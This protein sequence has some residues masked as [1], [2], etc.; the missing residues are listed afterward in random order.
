MIALIDAD[1]VLRRVGF[2]TE[3]ESPEIAIYRTDEMMEG[4]LAETKATEYE[5]WLSDHRE[6][7]FR[8]HIYPAYKANR[9]AAYPKHDNVIME[10][11][12]KEWGARFAFGME[13]DD[14]L[15]IAQDKIPAHESWTAEDWCSVICSI[16]KD[17]LQIPGLH[18]NF[19]KKEWQ[20]VSPWQGLQWFYQQ[21]LIGD[22]S[23]NV[24]GCRGIGAAKSQK[25]IQPIQAS[26]G[27]FAL[28]QK[29]YEIYQRQEKGWS[30]Q[31]V[32][33]RIK[34]AGNLLRIKQQEGEPNWDSLSYKML[35]ELSASFTQPE[36][37]ESTPSTEHTLATQVQEYGSRAAGEPMVDST[38]NDLP[39]PTL[40]VQ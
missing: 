21:I 23:D 4:I 13:A 31:E 38:P 12:I 15:G 29:V 28:L 36:Q 14:A 7:N 22:T 19:V 32:V 17:L 11:L 34:L 40:Q 8:R 2:S 3:N 25:A 37:V 27:E 16:D 9:T 6:N 24:P 10:H 20:E 26:D 18:Y 33:E 30:P 5:C 1:I 39:Q 35:Q